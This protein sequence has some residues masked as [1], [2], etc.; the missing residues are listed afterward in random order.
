MQQA[1]RTFRISLQVI[2][3]FTYKASENLF[4][5][6]ISSYVSFVIC[7]E[8]AKSI[9]S[10]WLSLSVSQKR[11]YCIIMK[12]LSNP[13][14]LL[15]IYNFVYHISLWFVIISMWMSDRDQRDGM[16]GGT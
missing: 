10:E 3:Y 16:N 4:S 14:Q 8:S 6:S 7:I 9:H 2:F 1:F 15:F 5:D 11:E 13:Q 12:V